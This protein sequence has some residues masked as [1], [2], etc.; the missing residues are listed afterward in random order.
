M[1]IS[2][3]PGSV[4]VAATHSNNTNNRGIGGIRATISLFRGPAK[5]QIFYARRQSRL[6]GQRQTVRVLQTGL[7]SVGLQRRRRTIASVQQSR[8][9]D[10][11]HS[12][13]V[14]ACG[15][16]S[17]HIAS[18]HLGRGFALAPILRK[19]VRSLIRSYVDH[20]R[21]RHLRRLTTR[22]SSIWDY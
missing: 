19:R 21:R 8:I 6:G 12:R 16:G 18:R 22:S 17:G 9:N 5:V 7:C 13:G 4:R 3:S 14:H 20:S 10:N 11:S 15:C 2:V 1:R